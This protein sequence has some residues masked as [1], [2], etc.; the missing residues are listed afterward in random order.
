M[1]TVKTVIEGPVSV[2]LGFARLLSMLLFVTCVQPVTAAESIPELVILNWSEYMDPATITAFEAKHKV[3]VKEIY[4][5]SDD[6]R[7][8]ILLQT[9]GKGFDLILT[10]GATINTYRKNGWLQPLP[11]SKIPNLKYIEKRWVSAFEGSKEYGVAYLWGT[12][13]IAYRKDLV[14]K[15]IT[16]WKQLFTPEKDLQGKILMVKSSRD[17]I[18][19]A[20]KSLGY[21]CN[22]ENADELRQAEALL[23]AQRP[24]VARYGYITLDENSILVKGDI[25]A[26]TVYGG[27]A[28]NVGEFNENITYVL[29]EEGG[30]IWVDYWLLSAH[31]KQPG[32]A[33]KFLDFINQPKIAAQNSEDL[34]LASPNTAANKIISPEIKNNPVIYPNN[35]LLSRSEFYKELSPLS[36]RNRASIFARVVR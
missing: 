6:A 15:P 31:S 16:S 30:N 28:L 26:A 25:V 4:F 12:L 19:M 9:E 29:P 11:V 7:D 5:E 22:S 10:N 8:Q 13:G 33:A 24:H 32:L 1:L 34:F 17:L 36:T 23:L 18:G 14:S 21:S 2:A 3:K 35:E 20:L 27:D